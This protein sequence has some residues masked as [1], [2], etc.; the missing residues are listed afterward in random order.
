[1]NYQEN[2]KLKQKQMFFSPRNIFVSINLF[3]TIFV[4]FTIVIS[5]QH[6]SA[7]S[8]LVPYL[9]LVLK[10]NLSKSGRKFNL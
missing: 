6:M 5:A 1:M 3:E 2:L 10:N 7:L 8:M 4:R 9:N